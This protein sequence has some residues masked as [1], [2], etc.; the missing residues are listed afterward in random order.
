MNSFDLD[1]PV[2]HGGSRHFHFICHSR[3]ANCI[4][5]SITK[6]RTLFTTFPVADRHRHPPTGRHEISV[7]NV[8]VRFNHAQPMQ[9]IELAH[10]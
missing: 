3:I 2:A 4:G 5:L 7:A 8:G 6:S 9:R 10:E 1:D